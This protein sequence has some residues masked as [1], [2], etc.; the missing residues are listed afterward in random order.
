MP[1]VSR[2]G[3]PRTLDQPPEFHVRLRQ[4]LQE[5]GLSSYALSVRIGLSRS[6]VQKWARGDGCPS[7]LN[8]RKLCEE[9]GVTSD[10]MIGVTTRTR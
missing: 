4:L 5:R 8:L 9:L 2:V 7:L 1:K 3:R 10:W 6:L